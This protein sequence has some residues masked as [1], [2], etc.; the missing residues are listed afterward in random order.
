M[1]S[2]HPHTIEARVSL[3][4][5]CQLCQ[6]LSEQEITAVAQQAEVRLA[7]SGEVI[8]QQGET[9]E[10]LFVVVH[11]RVKLTHEC[12]QGGLKLLGFRSYGEHFGETALLT[13]TPRLSTAVASMDTVLLTLHRT[14]VQELLA[15]SPQWSANLSRALGCRIHASSSMGDRRPSSHAVQV[16]ALAYGTEQDQKLIHRLVVP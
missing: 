15:V 12:P 7:S 2:P 11:G 5:G 6:G 14:S 9:S 10:L 16:V 13:Q 8:C 3:L 4:A 1:T